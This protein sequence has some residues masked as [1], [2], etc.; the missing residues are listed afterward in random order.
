MAKNLKKFVNPR[1]TRTVDLR[2]LHRLLERHREALRGLDLE[3]L[4]A[5]SSEEDTRRVIQDFFAGPEETYP[6]GLTADLHRIAELGNANGLEIILQQA[7][8]LGV[9]LKNSS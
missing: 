3:Q 5:G 6:D 4:E 9:R 7:A 8:R 1:F 2:L